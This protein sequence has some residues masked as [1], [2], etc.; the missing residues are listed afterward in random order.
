MG[1]FYEVSVYFQLAVPGSACSSSVVYRNNMTFPTSVA[2]V[3]G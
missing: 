2:D 3:T 1:A